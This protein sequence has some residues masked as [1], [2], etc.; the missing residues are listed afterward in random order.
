ML[1]LSFRFDFFLILSKDS[2]SKLDSW[3]ASELNKIGKGYFFVRTFMD[4]AL[5]EEEYDKN[6]KIKERDQ[7]GNLS[8]EMK[9]FMEDIR[10]YCTEGLQFTIQTKIPIYLVSNWYPERFE[11]SKLILAISDCFH[12]IQKEALLLSTNLCTEEIYKAKK[13]ILKKRILYAALLSGAAGAVPI[14]GSG[15]A[16]DVPLVIN[17]IKFYK[18]QFNLDAPNLETDFNN[19]KLASL[20]KSIASMGTKSYVL[21]VVAKTVVSE[22]VEETSKALSWVTLGI[23][24]VVSAAASFG[25]TYYILTKELEKIADLSKRYLDLKVET[26]MR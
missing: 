24:S 10:N 15:L 5:E 23:T 8:N 9:T 16:V 1:L 20:V 12:G 22:V 25:S 11:F 7:D 2:F 14:P 6:M 19:E 3:L 17:E 21:G 13:R 4:R 26:M 18:E